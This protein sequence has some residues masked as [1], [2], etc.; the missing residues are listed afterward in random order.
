MCECVCKMA[1]EAHCSK[2]RRRRQQHQSTIEEEKEQRKIWR[3]RK[4]AHRILIL[5]WLTGW[6]AGV[7]VNVDDNRMRFHCLQK[8]KLVCVLV[9]VSLSMCVSV[10]FACDSAIFR[11]E[12]KKNISNNNNSAEWKKNNITTSAAAVT[13]STHYMRHK[14]EILCIVANCEHVWQ[15]A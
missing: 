12:C 4:R 7:T 5:G 15:T 6:L 10:F 13:A 1:K 9:S 3:K 14:Y 2:R 8:M 11:M